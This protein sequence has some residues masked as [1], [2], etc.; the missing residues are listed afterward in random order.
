M[1]SF[2]SSLIVWVFA[3][4]SC[5]AAVRAEAPLPAA[6]A[7]AGGDEVFVSG[8]PDRFDEVRGAV[9][10]ARET[11]G[12]RYRV[13]VIDGSAAEGDARCRAGS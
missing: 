3:A 1:R 12:R 2:R 5:V 11:S 6:P 4:L 8:V 7:A 9:K 10:R 13:I